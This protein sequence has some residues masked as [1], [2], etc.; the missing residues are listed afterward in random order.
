MVI[1]ER[2]AD[3]RMAQNAGSQIDLA[4]AAARE[5]HS[6]HITKNNC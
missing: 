3:A 6:L 2:S 5:H 4:L 1:A